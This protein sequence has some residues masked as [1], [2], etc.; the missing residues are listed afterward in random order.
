MCLT[1]AQKILFTI[2][3]ADARE[4]KGGT[5]VNSQFEELA[6]EAVNALLERLDEMNDH[7]EDVKG[8]MNSIDN[9]L[10]EISKYYIDFHEWRMKH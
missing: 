9:S 5:R 2:I 7:L 1:A 8:S 4:K 10:E 6:V 3:L